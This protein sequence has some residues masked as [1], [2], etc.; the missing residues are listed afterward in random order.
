MSGETPARPEDRVAAP[1][2]AVL[3]PCRNEEQSVGTVV[4]DFKAALPGSTVYVYDNASTDATADRARAAGAILRTE[5]R[6]G[7][8]NVVRRMF[9]DVEADI[10]ILVDGDNTYDAAAAPAMVKQLMT[11]ELDMIVGRRDPVQN[12]GQV[13]PR[14]HGFGNH[15]FNR[16]LRTLFGG[17]FTDVFSGYRVMS[18]RFVKSFPTVSEGFEIETEMTAHAVEI[19]APC[20]EMLTEY[21]ARHEESASKLHTV[22]DGIRISLRAL[23]LFREMRPM[24]FFGILCLVLTAVAWAL[25]IPLIIE[26]AETGL[27]P[28][29]PTAIL[30]AAIQIV[31]LVCLTSGIVLDTVGRFRRDVKR[32]VYLS[33]PRFP[34]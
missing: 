31:G 23:H 6:P 24:R 32:L 10:Y 7:K 12:D 4:S 34:A 9:A 22:R 3:V 21:R 2:I 19:L 5:Q 16:I 33:I 25:G 1:R 18:R 20:G 30:A 29:F 11:E 15:M 8:G 13:Y 27:V 28:R 14:G 26:F 17:E